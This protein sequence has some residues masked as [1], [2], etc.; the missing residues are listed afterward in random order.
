MAWRAMRPAVAAQRYGDR[1]DLHTASGSDIPVAGSA[2]FSVAAFLCSAEGGT[3]ASPG[4]EAWVKSFIVYER[5]AKRSQA[6]KGQH[7]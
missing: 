6:L 5:R 7:A 2:R 3:Y 4:R 1:C